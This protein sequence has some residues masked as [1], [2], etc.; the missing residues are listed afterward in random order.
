MSPQPAMTG[1]LTSIGQIAITV[2]DLARAVAFYRDV[3]GLQFLFEAGQ[4]AFFDCCGTRLMLSPSEQIDSTY[5]SILYYK[6]PDIRAT[7]ERLRSRR[8]VFEAP[9]RVIA[10]MPDHELWMA[11]FRD[12]EDNLLGLMSEVR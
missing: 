11:F 2:R 9:P 8:V 5:S 6:T 7:A 12:S 10:K 3:L 1:A 4:M